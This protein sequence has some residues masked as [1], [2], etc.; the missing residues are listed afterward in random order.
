MG[1]LDVFWV[2]FREVVARSTG[3]GRAGRKWLVEPSLGG[4]GGRPVGDANSAMTHMVT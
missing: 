4:G 3:G 1:I 2:Y